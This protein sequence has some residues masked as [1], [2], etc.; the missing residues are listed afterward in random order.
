M[1]AINPL[2]VYHRRAPDN[3]PPYLATRYNQ[4]I[5]NTLFSKTGLSNFSDGLF[6]HVYVKGVCT[7]CKI[8]IEAPGVVSIT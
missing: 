3:I 6:R 1:A 2:L 7:I 8:S 5:K 4:I